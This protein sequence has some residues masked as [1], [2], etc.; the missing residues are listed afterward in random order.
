MDRGVFMRTLAKENTIFTNRRTEPKFPKNGKEKKR[1]VEFN[2]LFQQ[3][4]VWNRKYSLEG[5]VEKVVE[6]EKERS[7]ISEVDDDLENLQ[8]GSV[9]A[10][11]RSVY[12]R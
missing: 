1:Q 6:K 11:W 5:D 12:S 7:K 10:F 3:N 4:R 9:G 8:D 2:A